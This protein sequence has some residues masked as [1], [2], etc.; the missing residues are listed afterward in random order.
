M[1]IA[2]A[3]AVP[4]LRGLGA[5]LSYTVNEDGHGPRGPI[6][7]GDNAEY[8][9][10]MSLAVTQREQV[11][12][13]VREA[14]KVEM[15]AELKKPSSWLDHMADGENPRNRRQT[16]GSVEAEPS[17]RKAPAFPAA[18]RDPQPQR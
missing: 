12:D 3:T 8:G 1:L 15:S 11:A 18:L 9:L 13:L 4:H 10:G 2:N 17:R 16:C 7:F 5:K 14:L 6:P